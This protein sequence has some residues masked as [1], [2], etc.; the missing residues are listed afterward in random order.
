MD[1][2]R[3]RFEKTGQTTILPTTI[4]KEN[5]GNAKASSPANRLIINADNVTEFNVA[6]VF[7]LIKHEQEVVGYEY[8]NMST[9]Q[10][11]SD[12]WVKDANSDIDYDNNNDDNF[13]K[14][15]FNYTVADLVGAMSKIEKAKTTWFPPFLY[16]VLFP[17]SCGT[18][19]PAALDCSATS[20]SSR[21]WFT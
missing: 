3:L 14:T 13:D 12:E 10:P 1:K 16:F 5:S 20:E 2:L 17:S 7:E 9:W 21:R 6:V 4:T 15:D 19:F 11:V 18:I 8:A